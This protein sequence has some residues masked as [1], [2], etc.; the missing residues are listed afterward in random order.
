MIYVG[1]KSETITVFRSFWCLID[2]ESQ[3]I[4]KVNV[5]NLIFDTASLFEIVICV[6]MC[7]KHNQLSRVSAMKKKTKNITII[8]WYQKFYLP[9]NL[10]SIFIFFWYNIYPKYTGVILKKSGGISL[11]KPHLGWILPPPIFLAC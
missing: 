9:I 5:K 6:F 1:W 10:Y 4:K 3:I 8:F 11:L 2:F 7:R